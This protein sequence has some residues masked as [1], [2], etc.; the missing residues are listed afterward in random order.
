MLLKD[1]VYSVGVIDWNNREFHESTYKIRRGTTY[2]SYLVLD[3]KNVLIDGVHQSYKNQFI[4]NIKK[5]I[6]PKKI[7]IIILNHIEPDHSG[8][9]MQVLASCSYNVIIYSTRKAKE[10][11]LKYYNDNVMLY[12]IEWRTISSFQEI[13]IGKRT[14]Q[15]IETPMMHWPDSMVTY[16]KLDNILFSNDIFGQHYATNQIFDD[17]L[18]IHCSILFEE[19]KKY[20]ANIL[21]TFNPVIL[22][23]L[24]ILVKLPI[25][26]I[27][28]SHGLVWRKYIC[29]I[30]Q[31][32]INWASNLLKDKVTIIYES[33]WHS[34]EKIAYSMLEGVT[35]EHLDAYLFNVT[36]IDKTDI[37]SHMLDSKGW[38]IGSSTNNRQMLPVMS[39][40]LNCIKYINKVNTRL[41][42]VFGSY[43]WSGEAIDDIKKVLSNIT[44]TL[45]QFCF[46]CVFNPTNDE[47]NEC[48]NIA[49]Q[50]A[51]RIKNNNII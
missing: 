25:K 27:A 49:K 41:S 38:I 13:T 16:S 6:N 42:S 48:Y 3:K 47:L 36:K 43:G 40:L 12:N 5:I 11:F 39:T 15:F 30:T 45:N 29:R 35:S 33:M 26:L 7:D 14:L 37:L 31:Q 9:I 18:G 2:N 1:N 4:S 24:D 34:T 20:Y 21:W 22:S 50:F 28:P 19:A 8:A 46:S 32:Y 51:I 10:G 44:L 17:D 23:K